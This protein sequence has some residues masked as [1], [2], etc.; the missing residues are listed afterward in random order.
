MFNSGRGDSIEA[1]R[2]RTLAGK[3]GLPGGLELR[4]LA[5]PHLRSSVDEL[6]GAAKPTGSR[7]LTLRR[8]CVFRRTSRE[9]CGGVRATLQPSARTVYAG[10]VSCASALNIAAPDP[11]TCAAVRRGESCGRVCWPP[12]GAWME[13][14]TAGVLSSVSHASDSGSMVPK[15]NAQ[16]G[17]RN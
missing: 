2:A 14:N 1:F 9:A 11:L 7:A 4:A 10:C 6:E 17:K 13:M 15:R 5:P 3:H 8:V 12:K 16:I